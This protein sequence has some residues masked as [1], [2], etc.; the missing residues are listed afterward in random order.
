[1][2]ISINDPIHHSFIKQEVIKICSNLKYENILVNE[3]YFT[4][5][6]NT[7]IKIIEQIIEQIK[8]NE[9]NTNDLENQ[10]RKMI[11]FHLE[12]E[13]QTI[14]NSIEIDDIMITI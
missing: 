2:N 9:A 11:D 5:I 1:M 8:V 7:I 6:F 12:N 10:V 14:L 13:I 3:K 4:I